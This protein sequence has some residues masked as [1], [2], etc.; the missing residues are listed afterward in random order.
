VAYTE[1]VVVSYTEM[2]CEKIRMQVSKLARSK[3]TKFAGNRSLFQIV[4]VKVDC[5]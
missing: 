1:L 5:E 2:T 3:M 4:R